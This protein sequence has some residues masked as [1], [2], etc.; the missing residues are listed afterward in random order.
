MNYI[1]TVHLDL[2][3]FKKKK[4]ELSPNRDQCE[5]K[6][7]VRGKWGVCVCVCARAGRLG[8]AVGQPRSNCVHQPAKRGSLQ[9]PRPKP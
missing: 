7:G 3:C 8:T 4:A 5:E 9:L 6:D 2:G 1:I